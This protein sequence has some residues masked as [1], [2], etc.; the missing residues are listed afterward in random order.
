[1]L[2]YFS[3]LGFVTWANSSNGKFLLG[4]TIF[5]MMLEPGSDLERLVC[6]HGNVGCQGAIQLKKI[7]GTVEKDRKRLHQMI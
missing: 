1:M 2:M 5:E 4:A 3:L 7:C 6:K